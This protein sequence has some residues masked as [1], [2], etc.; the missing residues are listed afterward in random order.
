LDA[1]GTKS[2]GLFVIAYVILPMVIDDTLKFTCPVPELDAVN[3]PANVAEKLSDP[4]LGT[5]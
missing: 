5:V 3:V 2:S 1:G 4:A